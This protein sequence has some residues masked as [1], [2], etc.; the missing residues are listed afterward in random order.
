[1]SNADLIIVGGGLAGSEA[2]WQAAQHGLRVQI[3]EMRPDIS[4]GA[5]RTSNL[6]ELVCSN[7]WFDLGDGLL[8]DDHLRIVLHESVDFLKEECGARMEDWKWG[9]LHHITFNHALGSVKPLDRFF[10]RGPFPMGGDGETIWAC[11]ATTFDLSDK[12]V[13]GPP[14]RFIADLSDWNKSLG[15]LVPGQSGHPSS[16]SYDGSI[17]DWMNGE[18]HPILFDRDAVL[19]TADAVLTLEPV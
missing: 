8:R 2:A 18:Y 15:M 10:N 5:H 7:S 12:S 19:G 13:V 6:A 9:D 1:M 4:T 16:R 14:F 3:Y 11:T 17:Q